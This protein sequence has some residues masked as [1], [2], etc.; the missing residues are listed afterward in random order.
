M[1]L[2]A[3]K[4]V[5]MDGSENICIID[6]E[7]WTLHGFMQDYIVRGWA[8][9]ILGYYPEADEFGPEDYTLFAMHTNAEG[10]HYATP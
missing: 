7:N 10:G 9:E 8:T 6:A 3:T 2:I 1:S 4:D 5:H